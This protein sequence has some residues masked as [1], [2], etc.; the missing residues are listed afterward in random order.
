MV[1]FGTMGVFSRSKN[2]EISIDDCI[3][4]SPTFGCVGLVFAGPFDDGQRNGLHFLRW[5]VG[6]GVCPTEAY[7]LDCHL[8]VLS[9]AGICSPAGPHTD[10]LG[11]GP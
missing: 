2:V 6:I 4:T 9:E 8:E 1:I 5:R 3:T 11:D 10:L 7:K